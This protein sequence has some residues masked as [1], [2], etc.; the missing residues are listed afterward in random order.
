ML[1]ELNSKECIM[2]FEEIYGGMNLQELEEKLQNIT[3]QI[4]L[5][6]SRLVQEI[7]EGNSKG[8]LILVLEQMKQEIKIQWADMKHIFTTI[9]VILLVS[10]VFTAFKDTFQ[11][12]QIAEISF[13]I[14]YLLLS[15]IF[16]RL[17]GN[18]LQVGEHSLKNI[19][20]FMTIFFPT[21]FLVVGSI[22]GIGTG[23]TYYQL[24]GGVIYLVEWC[25]LSLLLP[26]ISAYMLFVLMNGVW[27]EERLTFLLELFQKGLKL[28]LKLLLGIITG[29]GIFQSMIVPIVDRIK[30]ESISKVIEAIP[31]IGEVAE[32]AFRVWIGSA[33]LIKNSIG[34]VGC[35]LLILL[36]L[37][38]M[39]KIA[40]AG[41]I[42]KIIAA[43]FSV[44]GDK[45]MINCT[46]Q[47]GDGVFLILQTVS[48][49]MLFFIVLTAMTIYSTNGG[50]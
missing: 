40:L 28:S 4:E 42:F 21:F 9:V 26:A 14:N 39:V 23:L 25:L 43:F 6:F 11:N 16:I 22:R 27:E 19:K 47:V 29:A 13:Y 37:S 41:G 30:G 20:E 35:I 44:V 2:K 17:F 5:P 34:V 33:V 38:P 36:C 10:A 7:Y 48:Y 12:A 15:V 8:I 1:S 24:A 46:N 32:G 49:G 50:F 45:K 31:G 3:F 18:I